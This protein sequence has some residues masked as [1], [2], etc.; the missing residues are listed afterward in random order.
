MD[1]NE[2][3]LFDD[4]GRETPLGLPSNPF[5]RKICKLLQGAFP[6]VAND[7][8]SI[9]ELELSTTLILLTLQS[10]PQIGLKF[11][12]WKKATIA[13]LTV[14]CGPDTGG[15]QPCR[16]VMREV[17]ANDCWDAFVGWVSMAKM[18]YESGELDAKHEA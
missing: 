1:D 13:M 3:T 16:S 11:S 6:Q 17:L 2:F 5:A 9:R 14:S 10:D 15:L 7:D 8:F 12:I 18:M 4:D